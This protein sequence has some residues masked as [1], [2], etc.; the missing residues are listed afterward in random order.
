MP[1]PPCSRLS[2]AKMGA[3]GGLLGLAV[4][5]C[6]V[7][8]LGNMFSCPP[9]TNGLMNVYH[10]TRGSWTLGL[11]GRSENLPSALPR[12]ACTG[13]SQS[14]FYRA[15][16]ADFCILPK[17][18]DPNY[19]DSFCIQTL[20]YIYLSP[21]IYSIRRQEAFTSAVEIQKIGQFPPVLPLLLRGMRK[22][23][24]GFE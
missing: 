6:M 5:L 1:I 3:N 12:V 23:H 21:G 17:R 22:K 11:A 10:M 4:P 19:P 16:T 20:S 2:K 7:I 18:G 14:V 8:A 24:D 9:L 15:E 13:I